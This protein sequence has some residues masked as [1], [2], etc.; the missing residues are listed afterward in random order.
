MFIAH[1]DEGINNNI[2]FD[3][4]EDQNLMDMAKTLILP[5]V[6]LK[7]GF[8]VSNLVTGEKT[9]DKR[10]DIRILYLPPSSCIKSLHWR[11]SGR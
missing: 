11:E 6:N 7:E 9:I 8:S 2:R 10:M 3:L 1:L 5:K 4:L